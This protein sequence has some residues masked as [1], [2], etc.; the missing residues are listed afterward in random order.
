M[1]I[2]ALSLLIAVIGAF[3][4]LAASNPKVAELGKIMF[5]CGLLSF[6][7]RFAVDHI[8]IG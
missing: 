3:L 4:Y 7:M 6:L 1:I 2:I 8:H 5:F